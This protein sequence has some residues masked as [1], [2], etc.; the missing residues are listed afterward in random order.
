MIGNQKRLIIIRDLKTS[1]SKS[2]KE[3]HNIGLLEEL[4]L[5]IY[6]R[7]WEIAHPGDLV[8]GVGI[9]LFSHKTSHNLE[10]S[11]VF[12]H[13]NKLDI[14]IISRTTEDLY[15]FPNE[16]NNPSS[17]QFRA[18][19]THRLSVSLGV[20]NNAKLGKVH[21]TPSK[22]VCTY[23]SVKQICDVKMEDGF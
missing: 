7:A 17:D 5:A 15:R 19:L 10:I 8:V 9:S 18:W 1:E 20:A 23:C 13:I 12:P 4:Q 16:N 14:G 2:S 22:K 3:R 21:P 6:A 11:N